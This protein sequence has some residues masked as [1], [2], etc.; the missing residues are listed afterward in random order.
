MEP[1]IFASFITSFFAGIAALFAPCCIG[2]LLPAYFGSVFRQ[3]RTVLIMTVVFFLGLLAVFVPLGLG[4]GAFG[5]LLKQYHDAIYL[6]TSAFLFLLGVSLLLGVHFSI[7]FR[8]KSQIKATGAKSVFVLGV[9]SGLATLCCAPVLAGALALSLLPGSTLLG[10]LYSVIYVL[11]MVFPLFIISYFVDK[12]DVME[13]VNFF[14]R[15]ITYR[16]LGREITVTVSN[17]ISSI[18]FILMALAIFYFGIIGQLGMAPS[19]A[20]LEVNIFIAQITDMVV[21]LASQLW[22]QILF[23]AVLLGIVVWVARVLWRRC[24]EVSKKR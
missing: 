20:Q 8:T 18:V 15:G 17:L 22:F 23:I 19:S 16:L 9:L 10:A 12:S 24:F 6:I 3:K 21:P 7:P 2:V 11:G 4:I 5:E 14:K 1:I 13:K